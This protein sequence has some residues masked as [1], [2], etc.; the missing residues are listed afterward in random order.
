MYSVQCTVYNVHVHG[1]T[2]KNAQSCQLTQSKLNTY[3]FFSLA[4][5]HHLQCLQAQLASAKTKHKHS[6]SECA[7]CQETAYKL[8]KDSW[9]TSSKDNSIKSTHTGTSPRPWLP[10]LVQVFYSAPWLCL[11]MLQPFLVSL[12]FH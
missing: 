4:E 3:Q 8:R 5:T 2:W 10:L 11:W 7:C 12:S 6:T 1:N 9:H